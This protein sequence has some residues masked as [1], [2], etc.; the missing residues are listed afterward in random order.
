MFV[1][2]SGI[3]NLV[4]S[5]GETSSPSCAATVAID[6]GRAISVVFKISRD[7]GEC[8]SASCRCRIALVPKRTAACAMSNSF[9]RNF[10][11]NSVKPFYVN[12]SRPLSFADR[13]AVKKWLDDY[14]EKGIM[15]PVTE[16][17]DWAASLVVTRKSDGSLCLCVQL[18]RYEFL[19]MTSVHFE[20]VSV[21][22][23]YLSFAFISNSIW[24][25]NHY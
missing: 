19:E 20:A 6:C 25:L 17:S 9:G 3:Q 5:A 16:P 24:Y 21:K 12:G 11:A 1:S 2:K 14:L 10:P 7:V 4:P 13:P 15:I 18:T 8:L 23:N 22:I